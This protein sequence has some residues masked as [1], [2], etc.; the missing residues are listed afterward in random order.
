MATT[1]VTP[2]PASPTVIEV[3][4]AAV[5]TKSWFLLHERLI[6]VV[7]CI[8]ATVFLANKWMT[9]AAEVDSAKSVLAT[10]V[11]KQQS[12]KDAAL[13]AQV[14]NT[15]AQYTQLAQ[16]LAATNAQLAA[17]IQTRTVVLQQQTKTDQT[18]ALPEVTQRWKTL[19]GLQPSDISNDATTVTLDASGARETVIALEQLPVLQINLKDV[20]TEN[21]NNQQLLAKS[22]DVVTGLSNQVTSLQSTISDNNTACNAKLTAANAIARKSKLKWFL[23]GLGTGAG[24]VGT[25]VIHALL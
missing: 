15:Q 11:A 17:S 16:Q 25:I 10:Q 8:I 21:T 6:I 22:Q 2:A 18:A 19:I 13:L 7:L 5:V 4:T 1:P 24:V 20:T 23:T 12:D 9:H 14:Q 3:Q